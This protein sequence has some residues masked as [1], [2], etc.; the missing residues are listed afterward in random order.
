MSAWEVRIAVTEYAV[1]YLLAK[2]DHRLL[3]GR[4]EYPNGAVVVMTRM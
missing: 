2:D 4:V 3:A 1:T